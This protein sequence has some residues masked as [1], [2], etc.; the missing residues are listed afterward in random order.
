[1]IVEIKIKCTKRELSTIKKALTSYNGNTYEKVICSEILDI[2][3]RQE[4]EQ[5]N[6]EQTKKA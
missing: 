6:K 4:D 2:I 1:M 3:T 5:A